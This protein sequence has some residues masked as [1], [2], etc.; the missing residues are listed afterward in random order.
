MNISSGIWIFHG[1]I[2]FLICWNLFIS[3]LWV[4]HCITYVFHVP[5]PNCFC[6]HQQG[7]TLLEWINKL[8]KIFKVSSPKSYKRKM[9]IQK[10][11]WM[12]CKCYNTFVVR[13]Y[14]IKQQFRQGMHFACSK[15]VSCKWGREKKIRA[16]NMSNH[17]EIMS[18][19]TSTEIQSIIAFKR[20][21]VVN[22]THRL[23]VVG[24]M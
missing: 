15:F 11:N 22:R 6:Q 8:V 20:I 17:S 14:I 24:R 12:T 16:S 10:Y 9:R 3:Y 1:I 21:S 18:R 7:K 23:D 4:N 2:S 13:A 19:F 5:S